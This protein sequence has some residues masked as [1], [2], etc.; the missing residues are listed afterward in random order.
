MEPPS[1]SDGFLAILTA[2]L[3][4][5]ETARCKRLSLLEATLQMAWDWESRV[6]SESVASVLTPRSTPTT[7]PVLAGTTCSCS[8]CTE[9]YQCPAC[10]VTVA[11]RILHAAGRQIAALFQAQA[12]QARQLNGIGKD[13]NGAGEPEA[14]QPRFL[15]LRLG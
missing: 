4:L 15:V 8:T 9:T 14:A 3:R 10:S 2:L 5:R 13:H 1:R 12:P 11:E 7:G 6:P